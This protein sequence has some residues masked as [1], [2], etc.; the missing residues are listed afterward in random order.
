[1]SYRGFDDLIPPQIVD[2]IITE[3]NHPSSC[4]FRALK[5]SN[6]KMVADDFLPSFEDATQPSCFIPPEVRDFT[7]I[8]YVIKGQSSYG[9]S[10]FNDL[11]WLKHTTNASGSMRKSVIGFARG[12][13]D[14]LKGIAG[15]PDNHTH[16]QY[17]LYN[18]KEKN[19]CR[20]FDVIERI[21]PQEDNNGK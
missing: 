2:Q 1:M 15:A 12:K 4:A 3:K 7:L 9:L 13:T 11:S 16:F 18:S 8:G 19:P 10:L 6:G 14:V 20:D 5:K 17:F 21:P